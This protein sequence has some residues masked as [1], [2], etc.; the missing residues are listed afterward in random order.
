MSMSQQVTVRETTGGVIAVL[1][2]APWPIT[3][4]WSE[5]DLYNLA[6]RPNLPTMGVVTM[7]WGYMPASL[8]ATLETLP[9]DRETQW[10]LPVATGGSASTIR[11]TWVQGYYIPPRNLTT[12]Q[13]AHFDETTVQL[14]GAV[15]V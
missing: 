9:T 1:A 11:W 14:H 3:W 15:E 4:E 8:L 2:F 10:W 13:K 12:W 6:G 5:P 7:R